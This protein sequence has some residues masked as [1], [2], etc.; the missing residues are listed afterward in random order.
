[1]KTSPI[2]SWL[3]KRRWPLIVFA[4]ALL[5]RL[6]FVLTT[7]DQPFYRANVADAYE[8]EVL[9][10]RILA[11]DLGAG[12]R[13]F[14]LSST[15]YPYILALVWTVFGKSL[16]AARL[17]QILLGS[18]TALLVF[19]LGRRLF[20]GA[21]EDEKRRGLRVGIISGLITALYGHL[22]FLDLELLMTTYEVF[23]AV[24]A[25]LL[26]TRFIQ[27]RRWRDLAGTGV[28]F[29]VACLGRP[30][31]WPVVTILA[32]ALAVHLWR[33]A[34]WRVWK[35]L[36]AAAT[37][38]GLMFVLI[39]PITLRNALAADDPVLLTCGGG[40]NLWIG[41]QPDANGT[42]SVPYSMQ[43]RQFEASHRLAEAAVGRPLKAS[44]SDAR[45]M[46]ETWRLIGDDPLRIA[47]LTLW[48]VLLFFNAY[49]MPNHLDYYFVRDEGGWALWLAPLGFWLV[50]PLC[51]GGLL[52]FRPWRTEH[53][54]IGLF[55][56]LYLLTIV[57]VFVTARFRPIFILA[58][59]PYA[60][61]L[62]NHVW[63]T[64]ASRNRRRL[65][66][67]GGVLLPAALL[68]NWG[69][70]QRPVPSHNWALM[71]EA[72]ERL[73]D[74]KG[75]VESTRRALALEPQNPH[76]LNNLGIY[77]LEAGD[78]ARAEEYMRRAYELS[79][80][81]PDNAA[82]LAQVLGQ[83]GKEGEAVTV[84]EEALARD[85][86]HSGCLSNLA[87]VYFQWGRPDIAL[88]YVEESLHWGGAPQTYSLAVYV[89][90]SLGRGNRAEGYLDRG[91]ALFPEDQG[92][93]LTKAH[94]HLTLG[95]PAGAREA[96]A[97]A[98][99]LPGDDPRL[100]ILSRQLGP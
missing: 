57:V 26:L 39:L 70:P 8:Y 31:L 41:N 65:L 90:L 77:A 15:G 73:G 74:R 85:P 12:D 80:R 71:A 16:L 22:V 7:S 4:A 100:E 72:R 92:L 46:N 25:V 86:R 94:L 14:F 11:G 99:S 91:L 64:L 82:N 54:L 67:I 36:G 50:M 30:N 43:D 23:F 13:V 2:A 49:E 19:F 28:A 62:L 76:L 93:L 21:E 68:V 33:R 53:R 69:V 51:L 38:I 95:D 9:A 98:R 6:V 27:E 5:P 55:A 24:L 52:L 42:F 44:E 17:I 96:L 29:G 18:A 89:C 97:R 81:N 20:S 88:G 37:V 63:E 34:G 40:L 58:V 59:V 45:W 48:K 35:A 47:G 66:I 79:D 87:V 61:W 10:D 1:V 75:A 3:A 78:L 32:L 60:G 84:L 83:R 56:L